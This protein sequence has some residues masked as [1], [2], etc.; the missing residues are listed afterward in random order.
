MAAP[1]QQPP[2]IRAP[3]QSRPSEPGAPREEQRRAAAVRASICTPTSGSSGVTS[4]EVRPGEFF[5]NPRDSEPRR[6]TE[7][8]VN[9]EP[10]HDGEVLPPPSEPPEQ[11][12]LAG[13]RSGRPFP[14]VPSSS[15]RADSWRKLWARDDS[16][17]DT[18][19]QW[20]GEPGRIGADGTRSS[21][22]VSTVQDAGSPRECFSHPLPLVDEV[23]DMAES[24]VP[25]PR[26]TAPP[27]E[28]AEENT[29][30][31]SISAADVALPCISPSPSSPSDSGY[32]ELLIGGWVAGT[33]DEVEG[34]HAPAPPSGVGGD[35]RARPMQPAAAATAA[36]A[37]AAATAAT[38]ETPLTV[39]T[40]DGVAHPE[41][42]SV[43][44]DAELVWPM[45]QPM[46]Y[47]KR[48]WREEGERWLKKDASTKD[49]AKGGVEGQKVAT[50][51]DSNSQTISEREEE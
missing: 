36:A 19:I 16:D 35:A 37:A 47:A 42:E 38:A 43:S 44:D 34:P 12:G 2:Q 24:S 13:G 3:D 22:S 33:G 14:G 32:L 21:S 7:L 9:D 20:T 23:L 18:E 48:S 25:P 28:A 39:A 1:E 51:S 41:E 11:F 45:M 49:A 4:L 5:G 27:A 17:E 30:A 46:K 8:T 10:Q 15:P 50:L 26:A 40:H 6:P 29:S 31:T